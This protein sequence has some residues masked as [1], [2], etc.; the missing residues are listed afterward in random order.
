MSC[1]ITLEKVVQNPAGVMA[2]ASTRE[3]E[4]EGA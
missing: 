3:A 2:Q 4:A 1:K